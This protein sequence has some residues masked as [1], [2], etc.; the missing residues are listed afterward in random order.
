M[1]RDIERFGAELNSE[2]LF[3]PEVFEQREVYIVTPRTTQIRRKP[4]HVT[5][6]EVPGL[7]EYRRVEILV[8]PLVDTTVALGVGAASVRPLS[9]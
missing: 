4:R 7:A 9:G 6:R 1:I 5:K 3:V 2:A 8:D